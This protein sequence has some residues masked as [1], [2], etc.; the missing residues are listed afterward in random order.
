MKRKEHRAEASRAGSARTEKKSPRKNR[1]IKEARDIAYQ[2]KDIASKVFAEQLK[3]KSLEAYGV[4]VGGIRAVLPTNIPAIKV[5]ELRL[6]N[7]LELQDG[8]VALVDYESEYKRESKVKYLNYLTGIV[9]RY[10][11][12]GQSCPN[13]RMIVVYTGDIPKEAVSTRYDVGA[14][15][16]TMEPAFLS[17]ID[18]EE[19]LTR[20]K[21]KVERG[22]R[23][24]DREQMEFIILPLSYRRREEKEER[25][26]ETIDLA[27]RIQDREQQIFVLAGILTFTD[28]IIDEESAG[29]IR[30]VIQMTK[31]AMI[32]EKEKEEA[33]KKER[34][35][36]QQALREEQQKGQQALREEQQ[37]GQQALR[38]ERQK[39]QQAVRKEQQKKQQAVKA[40]KRSIALKMIADGELSLKKIAMY[41]GM[42]IKTVKKLARQ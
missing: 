20:L 38:E 27:V 42:D 29:I 14:V 26:R 34:E 40:E 17:E 10:E 39:G 1:H 6:D 15:K 22:E 12:K 33:V 13:L 2:N 30:R 24:D 9:N 21:K 31:V 18:G 11:K 25:I 16:L 37:K 19:I 28:K 4:E 32:F 7:L 3:G 36:G 8:T 35:K 5:N 41:A 23:L